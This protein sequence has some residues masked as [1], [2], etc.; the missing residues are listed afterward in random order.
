MAKEGDYKISDI[1]Q[2]GYSS[3]SPPAGW[4]KDN[5]IRAGDLGMTTDPRNANILQEVSSKLSAGM[6]NI[7]VTAIQPEILDAIPHQHMKEV[8]RLSKLTGI[9]VSMHGP[10]IEAS[11]VTQQG[12]S[13]SERELAERKIAH[14]LIRSRD[15]NPDGN[16]P[17]TFHSSSGL[18]GSQFLPPSEREKAK[19]GYRRMIAVERESGKMIPLEPE[20][21]YYPDMKELKP[22]IRKMIEEKRMPRSEIKEEHYTEIPLEKGKS[23]T[24]EER[25]KMVNGSTWDNQIS[26]LFFNKERADEILE[27][28]RPLIQHLMPDLKSGKLQ[29]EGITSPEQAAAWKHYQNA[30]KYLEDV[31]KQISSLFSKAYEYSNDSQKQLLKGFSEQFKKQVDGNN[32]PYI[33]AQ[34]MNDLIHQLGNVSPEMYVPVE[35][36]AVEKSGQTYGNAAFKA[37][38]EFKGEHV[39]MMVIENPPAGGGLST[40]EDIKNIVVASRNSFVDNAMKSKKEGGL[41]MSEKD[42]KKQAEKLIGATWDVGHINMLRSQ[43]YSSE[44]IVAETEKVAP[45]VKHVHLSDNFG[46]EH[47]EL[48]MGMG[49]VPLKEMME[50]LGKQGFEAKKVIEAAHWWQHMKSS[51]FQESLEGI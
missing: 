1:Y 2:G 21:Q 6:K 20:I 4:T 26:Q 5:Y 30:E 7:E 45:Y 29:K 25:L 13:E 37:Y 40:G 12:F 24:P 15:L 42:A 33:Q 49:N 31:H 39:P 23:Y 44:D 11:G 28:N 43:G 48:P 51:P 38:K 10:L 8:N 3:L 17:V 36:F 35:E 19:S 22:E 50:K 46:M 16:I 27:K 9:D 14:A 41:E 34:A 47:T 32:D 18:P